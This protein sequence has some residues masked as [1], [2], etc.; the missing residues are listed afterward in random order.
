MDNSPLSVILV[1]LIFK[2]FKFVNEFNFCNKPSLRSVL[3]RSSLINCCFTLLNALKCFDFKFV[4]K[5]LAS[6]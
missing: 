2:Y 5:N 6:K 4:P 1:L 3:L